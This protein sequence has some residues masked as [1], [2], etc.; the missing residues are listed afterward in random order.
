[1]PLT[2]TEPSAFGSADYVVIG[3]GHCTH[4][5]ASKMFRW[6][7]KFAPDW[8]ERQV[9]EFVCRHTGIDEDQIESVKT[10]GS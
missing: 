7:A 8:A 4:V 2:I 9:I 3:G 10:L 6:G 5:T 1:M